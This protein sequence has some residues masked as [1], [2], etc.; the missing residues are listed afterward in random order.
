VRS[1]LSDTDL[2]D[3]SIP[4]GFQRF[5]INDFFTLGEGRPAPPMLMNALEDMYSE[6]AAIF[7]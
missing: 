2:T 5:G 6:A 4:S 7:E 1:C 3:R